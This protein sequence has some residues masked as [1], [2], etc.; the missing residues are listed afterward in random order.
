[1]PRFEEAWSLEP[2][3]QSWWPFLESKEQVFS[4]RC[5]HNVLVL[6][7]LGPL[8]LLGRLR[9]FCSIC[10]LTSLLAVQRVCLPPC[11]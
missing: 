10:L 4:C 1:M 5:Q 11:T 3:D 2:R 8:T 6:L 9:Y 7:L